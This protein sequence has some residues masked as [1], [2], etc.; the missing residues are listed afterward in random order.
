MNG[1]CRQCCLLCFLV[2]YQ[3]IKSHVF[4]VRESSEVKNVFPCCQFDLSYA[5]DGFY[6][7]DNETL[8]LKRCRILFNYYHQK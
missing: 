4:D 6:R 1:T 5:V 7:D 3:C 2:W 8:K